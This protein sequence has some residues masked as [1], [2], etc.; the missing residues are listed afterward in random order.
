M[1]LLETDPSIQIVARCAN[2]RQ[3][4]DEVLANARAGT[5][6]DVVVLD[7]EMPIMTGIEALPEIARADPGIRILMAST[8]TVRGADV[9]LRAM[10]LGAT[11]YVAKPSAAELAASHFQEELL[12][13]VKGLGAMRRRVGAP[14]QV[15]SPIALAPAPQHAPKLVAIGS[16]TGGP[17]A[18]FSLLQGLG[19]NVP[20]PVLITQHM[21]RAFTSMLAEHLTRLGGIQCS[22]ARDGEPIRPHHAYLA[23]GDRHLLV[24]PSGRGLVVRL[25]DGPAE[26]FCRPSVDPMLRTAATA[27]GGRVLAVILTGM[28]QDGLSGARQVVD[29]GGGVVAQDEATSVVWG[30]PG[31]VAKAGLCY[32]VA[33]ISAIAGHVL[34]SLG[35]AAA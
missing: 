17:Q 13:K 34:A 15:P 26:N 11:D 21:P 12:A 27:S 6:I 32:R 29:L 28:G 4:I 9:A 25:S 22:E 35:M 7:V 18:L 14:A 30:M 8:H 20:A 31:A 3:A 16:S 23:P 10:R 33:P 19:R 5:P 24:E 2:G 1:R